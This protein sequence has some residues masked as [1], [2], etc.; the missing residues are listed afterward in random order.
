MTATHCSPV[1]IAAVSPYLIEKIDLIIG[2]T[3]FY[4]SRSIW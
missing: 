1:A 3:G 4:P 2:L